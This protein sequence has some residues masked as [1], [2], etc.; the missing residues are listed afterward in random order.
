MIVISI[1]YQNKAW[2]HREIE[3]FYSKWYLDH[4]FKFSKRGYFDDK[5]ESKVFEFFDFINKSHIEQ[6]QKKLFFSHMLSLI[7]PAKEEDFKS[8]FSIRWSLKEIRELVKS[9]NLGLSLPNIWAP[10][11]F[12]RVNINE[13]NS[14]M[15]TVYDIVSVEKNFA[16]L[17]WTLE[18][19][20]PNEN[21]ARESILKVLSKVLD[22]GTPFEREIMIKALKNESLKRQLS[23]INSKA[24]T[25]YFQIQ[26]MHYQDLLFKGVAVEYSIYHLV[27]M[28][29]YSDD[30]LY[31]LLLNK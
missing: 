6:A 23:K 14:Y 19:Y 1:E 20:V 11:L 26:R 18:L 22:K 31:A 21:E 17:G 7:S 24:N 10:I 4:Y 9:P 8:K 16:G 12:R 3:K 29:D 25:P 15:E 30:I 27:S 28:G 5:L 2:A 13:F